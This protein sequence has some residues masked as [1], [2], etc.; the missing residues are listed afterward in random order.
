[1]VKITTVQEAQRYHDSHYAP[2]AQ[3]Q[4][5]GPRS[6]LRYGEAG[7]PDALMRTSDA[8]EC[9]YVVGNINA[10]SDGLAIVG[11]RKATPYGKALAHKFALNAAY[12]GIPV[13]SGGALGCDSCAHRGALAG[14]GATVVVLGGGCDQVY[15]ERNFNL[16]Q[17][18]ID[19]G[20]AVISE[21]QWDFPPLRHTFRLRN[22]IIA[23]LARATL[24]VEAGLPSGTFSTADDALAAGREVMAVPGS[25]TSATSRGAN[26]L[27]YQ[28]A[29]PI[30]DEQTFEDQLV[31]L[32]GCLRIEDKRTQGK[33]HTEEEGE[34]DDLLAALLANPLM[35]E[36]ML[37]LPWKGQPKPESG[38]KLTWLMMKLASYERDGVIARFPDG[39]YGPARV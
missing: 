1:M 20:G 6:V 14:Q 21:Q 22:R 28:G 9:L 35:V 12:H 34:R 10:L 5:Q 7:Y 23:G 32:F 25:I 19:E 36:Q 37:S 16:F 27:I 31:S 17:Q 38:E 8:P 26:R 11:A 15:P 18:V 39:R 13:V 2:L 33:D 4:L 30:V 24:I 3:R 29:T